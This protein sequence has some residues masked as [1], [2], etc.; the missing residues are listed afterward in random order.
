MYASKLEAMLAAYLMVTRD[1]G[2]EE[3]Q[4]GDR[5]SSVSDEVSWPFP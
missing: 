4:S 3:S 5:V 1:E 2:K